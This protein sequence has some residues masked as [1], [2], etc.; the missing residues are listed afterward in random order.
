MRARFL[1][2]VSMFISDDLP[3]LLR[4]IKANSGSTGGGHN[5]W[6]VLLITNFE[7]FISIVGVFKIVS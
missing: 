6:S 7:S 3:T 2:C 4:P 5:R 1:R